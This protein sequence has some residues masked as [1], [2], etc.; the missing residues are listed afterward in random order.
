VLNGA[1]CLLYFLG[2]N[3]LKSGNGY[4]VAM[5]DKSLYSFG[6]AHTTATLRSIQQAAHQ[7]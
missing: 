5:T 3:D 4:W 1:R 2:S 7:R 6:S